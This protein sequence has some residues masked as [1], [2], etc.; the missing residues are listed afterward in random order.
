[1]KDSPNLDLLRAM[2]VCFWLSAATL[3]V[4]IGYDVEAIGRIGVALFFTHTAL[5][6]MLSLERAPAAVPFFI[7]R[8]FR[9]YPLAM[10]VVLILALGHWLGGSRSTQANCWQT[11]CSCRT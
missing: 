8:F 9:I 4:A 11:S 7:R 10:F 6:L 1:V 5:V 3:R 2:A